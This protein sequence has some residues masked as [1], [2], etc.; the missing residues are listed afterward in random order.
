MNKTVMRGYTS[1]HR[2][3]NSC[4]TAIIKKKGLFTFLLIFQLLF[5]II[6]S[7]IFVHY[8]I[9][10]FDDLVAIGAPLETLNLDQ[11]SLQEGGK[12]VDDPFALLSSYKSLIR[13]ITHLF[14]WLG[15]LFL[16]VNPWLWIGASFLMSNGFA[17]S[18]KLKQKII[19]FSK[20]WLKYVA[21]ALVLFIPFGLLVYLLLLKFI[22]VY[23]PFFTTIARVFVG[24]FFV[25]FFV[26]LMSNSR[27]EVGSW[28]KYL[29]SVYWLS[30]LNFVW[31]LLAFLLI[32]GLT[33][34]IALALYYTTL[35]MENFPLMVISAILL[36]VMLVVG[37][38]FMVSVGKQLMRK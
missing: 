21:S 27:I 23:N 35:V 16:I 9:I 18:V 15:V 12:I 25:L 24:I 7:S 6:L 32:V 31:S 20:M 13:N 3:I 5:I 1:F 37:K 8:Q 2:S 34:L 19:I 10:L 33:T 4:S 22:G 14:T 30:I 17:S 36:I 11:E 29:K 26:F 38:I 28:K